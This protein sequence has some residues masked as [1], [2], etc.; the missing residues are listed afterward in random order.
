MDF[1]EIIGFWLNTIWNFVNNVPLFNT[2]F[3]FGQLFLAM[4]IFSVVIRLVVLLFWGP[5]HDV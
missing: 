1:F 5:S 3:T 4:L 2:G